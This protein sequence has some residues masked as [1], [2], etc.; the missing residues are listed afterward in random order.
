[1]TSYWV[2]LKNEK[3]NTRIQIVKRIYRE[4]TIYKNKKIGKKSFTRKKSEKI[5][6]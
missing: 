2:A 5:L 1:L 6:H 3:K 4:K